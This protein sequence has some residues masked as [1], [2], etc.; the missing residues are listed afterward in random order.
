M[1]RLKLEFFQRD[2]DERGYWRETDNQTLLEATVDSFEDREILMDL[3][4]TRV[5]KSEP[6]VFIDR[7]EG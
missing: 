1:L 6:V 5:F 7:Q 4:G 2:K 3:L